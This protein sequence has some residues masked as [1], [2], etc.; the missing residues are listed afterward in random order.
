MSIDKAII[1]NYIS[2]TCDTWNELACKIAT[3]GDTH[4]CTHTLT[5]LTSFRKICIQ[6]IFYKQQQQ[7]QPMATEISS[8]H[9]HICI[10]MRFAWICDDDII[11]AR[12]GT[13][14]AQASKTSE[15]WI[16]PKNSDVSIKINWEQ[17]KCVECIK[18]SLGYFKKTSEEKRIENGIIIV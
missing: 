15:T 13:H 11:H 9:Y 7:Q 17:N 5:D 4:S 12:T 2:T 18:I 3:Q 16:V 1:T 8:S 14:I 6:I 10:G